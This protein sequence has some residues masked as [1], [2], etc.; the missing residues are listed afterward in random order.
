MFSEQVKMVAH[1]GFSCMEAE[2]SAAAF[3]AA[4][5]RTHFGV[6]TDVHVT[7][8]GELILIHDNQ[9]GRVA[10]DDVCVEQTTFATL[11]AL[12]LM[13]KDGVRRGDLCLPTLREY[14]SICKKYGKT[15]VLELKD[16]FKP[17]YVAKVID[18]F[19]EMEWLQ[20]AVFISFDLP[21]MICIR[22]MLPEQKAQFLIS[23]YPDWLEDTLVKYHLDL[24]IKYTQ[25]TK[26]R[27]DSLHQ[28]GIQVNA[29]TVD[30]PEDA[31]RLIDWGIDYI[32]SNRLE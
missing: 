4:G 23:D 10:G 7:A 20:N 22:E 3:V 2:N 15:C 17:A 26:E 12:R 5:N 21:N 32:T 19:K 16:H 14:I 13:D 31:Q 18:T 6:E 25:L 8:D 30:Q 27:M 1:R 29:W 11:R 24:D 28:K 9:T